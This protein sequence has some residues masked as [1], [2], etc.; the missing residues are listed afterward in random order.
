[1]IV[2]MIYLRQKD[3]SRKRYVFKEQMPFNLQ[4]YNEVQNTDPGHTCLPSALQDLL[5]QGFSGK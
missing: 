3:L 4:K 1:M 2:S 5:P